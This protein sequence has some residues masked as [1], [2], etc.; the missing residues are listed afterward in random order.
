M[1]RYNN[2]DTIVFTDINGNQYSVKDI[3]PISNQVPAFEIEKREDD[4]LDEIASRKEVFGD[5]GETQSW[6]IFDL[7][8]VKLTE[9]NFDL[10]KLKRLKISV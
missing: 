2:V 7:N 1:P 5:F 8:I 10:T 6:R 9:V 4:L 3:R